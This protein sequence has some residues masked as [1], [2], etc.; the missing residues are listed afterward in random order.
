MYGGRRFVF[1]KVR[2]RYSPRI[3]IPRELRPPKKIMMIDE[4]AY[5]GTV[6]APVNFE[7]RTRQVRKNATS[8]PAIP[9]NPKTRTGKSEKANTLSFKYLNLRLKDQALFPWV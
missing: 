1:S 2:Q 8:R 7:T 3:A 9:R 5:P 6:I 4:A